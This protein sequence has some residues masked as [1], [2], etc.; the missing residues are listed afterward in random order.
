MIGTRFERAELSRRKG[1]KEL[2]SMA[3]PD[4]RG[5]NA[6]PAAAVAADGEP[7]QG[8]PSSG[9]FSRGRGAKA[10]LEAAHG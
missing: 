3:H 9:R 10:H 2:E 5:R 6:G 1:R 7:F 8:E 4:H